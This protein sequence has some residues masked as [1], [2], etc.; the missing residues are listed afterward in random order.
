[1]APHR[2]F[3]EAELPLEFRD[4]IPEELQILLRDYPRDD[5]PTHPDFN[6]LTAFWL[7]RHMTF[8]K[9][10]KLMRSDTESLIDR[11]MDADVYRQR[12]VKLGTTFLTPNG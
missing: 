10:M 2:P 12:L 4:G 1:M 7:E 5:W 6:G 11:T 8:R 3:A 9:L